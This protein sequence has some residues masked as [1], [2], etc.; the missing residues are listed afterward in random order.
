MKGIILAG[1]LGTRLYPATLSVCKQLLPV[2]D[3]P[4]I[5]Y[6][7]SVLMLANIKDILIISRKEDLG[8]FKRL[9][10][11]GS[12]LGIKITYAVQNKPRGLVDAFI[13]GKKFIKKENVC[14]VLGD[15]LFYG[16]GLPKLLNDAINYVE[17][18]KK[19]IIFSYKVS[20]PS[21][22][23]VVKEKNNKIHSIIE[24]P[25][26]S[27]SKD[28][29]IGLYV[30]PNKVI[31]LSKKI[32]PSKRGELE[33]TDLNNLF[34]KEKKL[35]LRKFGRGFAWFDTGSAENLYEA[36][37]LIRIMEKRIGYK[38]GCPEEISFNKNWI[39]IKKYEKNIKKYEKSEYGKYLK[40]I[41]K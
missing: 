30:Y 5:F 23:G 29:I 24:K 8:K 2:Y 13:I 36:S 16:D 20:N 1:G 15:N 19:A 18:K 14:L 28:A 38:I 9:L 26:N 35:E 22:Y 32:K 37:Q 10:G 4:M 27:K 11:N 33:I 3:K 6:P 41:F 21:N 39:G 17:N 7:L 34:L 40:E 31:E 25:K 12:S